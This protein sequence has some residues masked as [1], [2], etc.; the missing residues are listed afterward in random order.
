MPESDKTQKATPHRRKKAREQGQVAR[1]REFGN[2]FALIATSAMLA[3][4]CSNLIPRW[5]AFYQGLLIAACNGDIGANGPIW[6]WSAIEVLRWIV[7][8]LLTAMVL[9]VIVSLAQGGLN[10]AP[11]ALA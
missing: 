9:S 3:V 4:M 6:F 5:A 10:F 7:P 8:I 11:S 2:V 1:S